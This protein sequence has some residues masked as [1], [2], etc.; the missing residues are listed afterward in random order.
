MC[1]KTV[2]DP[3][4]ETQTKNLVVYGNTLGSGTPVLPGLTT[5]NV[6]VQYT[7]GTYVGGIGNPAK[8]TVSIVNYNHQPIFDLAKFTNSSFSTAVAVKPSVTMAYLLNA[9]SN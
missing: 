2:K 8:V 9:Q 3:I 4:H 7:G 6:D 1:S 5:S